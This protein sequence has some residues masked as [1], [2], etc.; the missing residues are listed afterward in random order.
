M[1]TTLVEDEERLPHLS[2]VGHPAPHRRTVTPWVIAIALFFAPVTWGLQLLLAVSLAGH[3]CFPGAVPRALPLW[4]NL[5]HWLLAVNMV[6]ITL[7]LIAGFVAWLC[8]R[9]TRAERPGDVHHLLESGDGRT[10]F[11]AMAGLI[12]SVLFGLAVIF[13]CINLLMDPTCLT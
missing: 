4:A 11:L 6:A 13:Q 7:C 9:R 1:T 12:S 5:S 2:G 3:A 8:W 10:R